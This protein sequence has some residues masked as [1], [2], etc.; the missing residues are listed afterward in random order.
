MSVQFRRAAGF[1]LV[2]LM[3]A[4]VA[5]L[6]VMGAVLAF[7]VSSVRANSDYVKTARLTQELRNVSDH[8]TD[9]L[10]RAGY[11]ESAMNYIGSNSAS[12]A[13]PFSPMLINTTTGANCVIYA[14]DREP[15]T[16][17]VVDTADGEI[18]GIRRST[19]TLGSTVVGVVEV[20]ESTS[21]VTPTCSGAN[22]DYTQYP[23]SC[24][25]ASGWCPLSDPR[26][27]DVT[28]FTMSKTA[29]CGTDGTCGTAD[30][31]SHGLQ[32]VSAVT[33][34]FPM[35][36]RELKVSVTAALRSDAS[37][38]RSVV[39]NIKVRSDCL[40]ALATNCEVAPAP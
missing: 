19:A 40:R 11:D 21:T 14:Y 33:G 22:P 5:G 31:T 16:P 39:S 10:R 17:G 32:T 37:I 38:S 34:F 29:D 24:N 26:V 7:T 20:A 9:E 1:S 18:R 8:V 36:I 15:G 30:D 27:V 4:L 12:A 23:P 2:E 25:T 28:T 13:S 6:I 3:V 35:E